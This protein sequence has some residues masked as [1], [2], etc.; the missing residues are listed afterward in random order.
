MSFLFSFDRNSKHDEEEKETLHNNQ[1]SYEY[2]SQ[3]RFHS[4]KQYQLSVTHQ[5][6]GAPVMEFESPLP[7]YAY[8]EQYQH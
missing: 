5:P 6:Q 1:R 7:R 3:P 2:R 4:P 8:S